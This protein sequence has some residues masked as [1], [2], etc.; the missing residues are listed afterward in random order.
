MCLGQATI[1]DRQGTSEDQKFVAKPTQLNMN[2]FLTNGIMPNIKNNV[3]FGR[4]KAPNGTLFLIFWYKVLARKKTLAYTGTDSHYWALFEAARF[5]KKGPLL[6]I[7][8]DY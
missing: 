5:P 2:L 4:A 7:F 8:F 1:A 6:S 3:Q